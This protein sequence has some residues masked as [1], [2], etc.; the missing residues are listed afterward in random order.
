ME[1]I[2]PEKRT[3]SDLYG[4]QNEDKATA[5]LKNA[6][7]KIIERNHKNQMGEIDI[8]AYDEKED[9]I[10]FVEVKARKNARFG[11]GREAVNREKIFKITSVAQ[12]FLKKRKLQKVKMRFDVIEIM[13]E[14]ITHLKA[15]L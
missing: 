7:Y 14:N 10:I 12:M 9:R 1:F 8:I 5:F 3:R 13:G 11:Y 15:I 4:K 2:E 6:G